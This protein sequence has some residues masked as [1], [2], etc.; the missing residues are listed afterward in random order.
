MSGGV[1]SSVAAA[2]LQEQG[3]SVVGVFMKFW[4]PDMGGEC[5]WKE[6]REDAMR[7]AAK[8]NIP[9]LTW[10]FRK[11]YEQKVVDYMISSYKA[12]I[13]PN[14]DLMC[15]KEIKFGMFFDKAIAEGA[16]FVATGHYARIWNVTSCHS[17]RSEESRSGKRQIGDDFGLRLDPSAVPQ[18]DYKNNTVIRS[19]DSTQGVPF[20]ARDHNKNNNNLT[21]EQFNNYELQ[22]AV[23]LNKD[24]SYF[25][26]LLEQRHLE[27]TLF[28]I[29]ELTK[30]EV[31]ELAKKFGL[32][33]A[34]KKESQGVCFIGPLKMKKF[35]TEQIKPKKGII[36]HV[37][38]RI[39]G[40]HDGV[41]YYTIGQRH[42]FDLKLGGGPY[43]VVSKDVE[44]NLLIVGEEKDL[45]SNKAILSN[46][47]WIGEVPE[48]PVKLSVK[49]RYRA[50][51]TEATLVSY[52]LRSMNYGKL[53]QGKSVIHNSKYILRFDHPVRALTPGQ[54]VVFYGGKVVL[55]GGTITR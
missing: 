11:E 44:S 19:P 28:P 33:T 12:G 9:L 3:Y 8:L 30:P 25:L 31:R 24:Q 48:L 7:V 29:G 17:E 52:E 21:I 53:S 50:E 26:Y 6:E 23:D 42:G 49:P 34:D 18:D 38:G 32:A 20:G 4:S 36:K 54:A 15:N 14:P 41:Y 10:D 13:T 45:Y 40:E 1:D 2:L 51:E 46:V 37:D 35:L 5:L 39:L 16:D 27:K 55:G 47:H 43:F 22:K